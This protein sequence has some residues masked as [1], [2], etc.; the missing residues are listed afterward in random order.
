MSDKKQ[1]RESLL[2]KK[3]SKKYKTKN[4]KNL[5]DL[6]KAKEIIH[7]EMINMKDNQIKQK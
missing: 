4:N 1:S 2:K 7:K 5:F 6:E 3:S